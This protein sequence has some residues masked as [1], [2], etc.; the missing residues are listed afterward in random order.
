MERRIVPLSSR[1]SH[2][3]PRRAPVFHRISPRNRSREGARAWGVQEFMI[4]ISGEE[5]HVKGKGTYVF[6]CK[7]NTHAAV[8]GLVLVLVGVVATTKQERECMQM[9]FQ[10]FIVPFANKRV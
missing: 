6:P 7:E 2:V 5:K 4:S 3:P 10:C 1:I 9:G 8:L